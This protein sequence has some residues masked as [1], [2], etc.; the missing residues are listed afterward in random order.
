MFRVFRPVRV[1]L[2]QVTAASKTTDKWSEG[3]TGLHF[4]TCGFLIL[5]A[6]SIDRQFPDIPVT[7]GNLACLELGGKLEHE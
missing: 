3:N 5:V 4:S 6:D 2:T 1:V 7:G